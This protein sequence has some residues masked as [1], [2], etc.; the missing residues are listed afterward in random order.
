MDYNAALTAGKVAFVLLWLACFYYLLR[1]LV[2]F[3]VRH[4][5]KA[6][7]TS[8]QVRSLLAYARISHPY[9][10]VII[11]LADFYHAYVMWLTHD[12]SLKGG[13]GVA[14]AGMLSIMLLLGVRLKLQPD[15]TMI[16][17]VHRQGAL[18]II[19]LAVS[20]RLA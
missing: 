18:L 19:V 17:L 3:C 11:P 5:M 1:N 8:K 16:R 9:L 12:I 4:G 14:T 2:V 20:H 7:V 10:A 15:N 13:L 6:A